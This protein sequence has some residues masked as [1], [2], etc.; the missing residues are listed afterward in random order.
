MASRST[1]K[2][3]V[4]AWLP[5]SPRCERVLQADFAGGASTNVLMEVFTGNTGAVAG[6]GG[7]RVVGTRLQ[8]CFVE[9]V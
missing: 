9:L 5:D 4:A 3:T 7:M 2:S 1:T 6:G 8:V